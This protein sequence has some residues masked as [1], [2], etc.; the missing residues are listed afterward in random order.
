MKN[1]WLSIAAAAILCGTTQATLV[2]HWEMNEGSGLT[3]A[4]S[5]T[6]GNSG[7]FQ[8][9]ANAA[10]AGEGPSWVNDSTRG[11]ALGFN[12]TT[13]YIL[14]DSDGVLGDSPRTV[15]CWFY[16]SAD[17]HR[18]TLVEWGDGNTAAAYFRMLIE[19]NRLRM[20]VNGGNSLALN[21]NDLALGQWYHVA[22]VLDDFNSDG[23]VATFDAKFYLNG[24]FTPRT[25]FKGLALN[26]AQNGD[27]WVRLGGGADYSSS[28][29]PREALTGMLDDVRIY[30][31]ALS[32]AEIAALVVPE[33][34]SMLL[35]AAGALAM[36]R[37]K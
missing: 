6:G 20:E 17:Q 32:D 8:N 36:R 18:H 3:V 34:A 23:K 29:T 7:A 13:D 11:T 1:V 30:D 28:G 19:D 10:A 5:G 33:P 21:T 31:T 14:T 27:D 2:N 25:A 35:L 4:D 12:G 15:A 24:E 16:L 22:L 37:R 9:G 26:T